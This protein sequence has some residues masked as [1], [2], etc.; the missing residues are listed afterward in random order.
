MEWQ[1]KTTFG[2]SSCALGW[3]RGARSCHCASSRSTQVLRRRAF[4]RLESR[5]SYVNTAYWSGWR[6]PLGS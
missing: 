4:S 1:M 6:P 3:N 2:S 5:Q